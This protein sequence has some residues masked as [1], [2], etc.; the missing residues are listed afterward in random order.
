MIIDIYKKEKDRYK[1]Y[2]EKYTIYYNNKL[3]NIGDLYEIE[4]I[5]LLNMFNRNIYYLPPK[6]LAE[7]DNLKEYLIYL[8]NKKII[9]IKNNISNKYEYK[10]KYDRN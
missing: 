5:D 6:L 2:G 9:K 8:R 10:L 1:V 3:Y 4:I 7:V